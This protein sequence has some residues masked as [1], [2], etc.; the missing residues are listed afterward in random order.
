MLIAPP[1][2]KIEKGDILVVSRRNTLLVSTWKNKIFQLILGLVYVKL[3]SFYFTITEA[4]PF[5]NTTAQYT[6]N[7]T[8]AE[9]N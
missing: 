1:K 6:D 2:S 3:S 4:W 7:L 5:K 8:L 9:A